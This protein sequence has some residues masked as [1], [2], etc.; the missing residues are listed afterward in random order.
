MIEKMKEVAR[1]LN[2]DKFSFFEDGV[3]ELLEAVYKRLFDLDKA[4]DIKYF[5]CLGG[6]CAEHILKDAQDSLNKGT[7]I[8]FSIRGEYTNKQLLISF[9]PG[10]II[11]DTFMRSILT[12]FDQSGW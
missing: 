4:P 3:G 6:T 11:P 8:V 5:C 12:R 9:T 1:H 2:S 7:P 10:E